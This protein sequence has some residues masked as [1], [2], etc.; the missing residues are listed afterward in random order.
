MDEQLR[1]SMVCILLFFVSIVSPQMVLAQEYPTKPIT[2]LVPFGPGG[3][4][5]LSGRVLSS[6]AVDYLGQPMIIQ[7]KPGGQGILGTDQVAKASPD[8]YTLL[9][10]GSGW[11]S[12]LPVGQKVRTIWRPSAALTIIRRCYASALTHPSKPSSK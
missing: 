10:A 4:S 7:L 8:G 6:V 2:L 3:D 9:A 1:R 5:D 12:A 11:N